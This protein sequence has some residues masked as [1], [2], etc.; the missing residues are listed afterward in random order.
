[1]KSEGKPGNGSPKPE[2]SGMQ[3]L[4][5]KGGVTQILLQE[6]LFVTLAMPIH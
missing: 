2:G 4:Y 3:A 5:P 6:S 1:M